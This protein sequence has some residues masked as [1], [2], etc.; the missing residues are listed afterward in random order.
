MLALS[1]QGGINDCAFPLGPTPDDGQIF[2]LYLSPLHQQ[3]ESARDI[4][5]LRHQ[6]QAAGLAVEA[7][8]NGYLAAGSNFER[9]KP[10]QFLPQRS[11][12]IR[13]RGMNQEKR[14]FIDDSI[15]VSFINDF[16]IE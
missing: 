7:I 10:A 16:E 5:F 9:E 14:R 12:T 1:I 13:F 3:P 8:H 15:I 11:R 4:G 2:F 6:D